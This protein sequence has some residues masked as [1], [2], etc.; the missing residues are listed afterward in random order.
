MGR[1]WFRSEPDV[2]GISTE[3]QEPSKRAR[4]SLCQLVKPAPS[5]LASQVSLRG[6]TIK[7]LPA[8]RLC[9]VNYVVRHGVTK[10]VS[11]AFHYQMMFSET[12]VVMS[13]EALRVIRQRE[14]EI[15]GAA[16]A[17]NPG[18]V[19][20]GVSSPASFNLIFTDLELLRMPIEK[21][22]IAKDDQ[23]QQPLIMRA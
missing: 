8:T 16:R 23:M 19:P 5:I 17:Q 22:E 4:M 14:K 2:G 9:L 3:R 12:W 21:Y 1:F 18:H 11:H 6:A 20:D 13:Y 7:P 15:A 10:A